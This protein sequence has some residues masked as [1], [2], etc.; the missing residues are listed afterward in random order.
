MSNFS[1]QG[2]KNYEHNIFRGIS[3]RP[4]Q[5]ELVSQF[6]D[7]LDVSQHT[8]VKVSTRSFSDIL[9]S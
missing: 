8:I 3:I 9:K 2:N 4:K 5:E 6:L 1:P 7:M